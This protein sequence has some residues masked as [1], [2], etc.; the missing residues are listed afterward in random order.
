MS[1]SRVGRRLGVPGEFFDSGR[2]PALRGV[3]PECLL[4]SGAWPAAVGLSC[5]AAAGRAR[6]LPPQGAVGY[7]LEE[8]V[9]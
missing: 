3:L 5:P 6:A 9:P 8:I 7:V 4:S 1:P 2:A